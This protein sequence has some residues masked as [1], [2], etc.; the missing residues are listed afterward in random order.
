MENTNEKQ[1]RE[2]TQ[3]EGYEKLEKAYGK[4]K[5]NTGKKPAK[6]TYLKNTE[7]I[8]TGKNP[9]KLPTREK[10][11]RKLPSFFASPSRFSLL[12]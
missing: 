7:K 6:N 11:P 2:L 12:R 8:Y 3:K 9:R 5:K 10:N 4:L 1:K